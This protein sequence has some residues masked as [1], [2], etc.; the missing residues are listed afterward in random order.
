MKNVMTSIANK[1]GKTA[2]FSIATLSMS[3]CSYLEPYQPDTVQG[4]ILTEQNLS[5]LQKGLS[6]DQIQQL[7][8]PPSSGKNAFNPN[9]WEYIY[10]SW[11]GEKKTRNGEH[12][13]I[14]FD[15]EGYVDSWSKKAGKA[16]LESQKGF[17]GLGIF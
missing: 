4:N 14:R 13:I 7:F 16:E 12:L 1:F 2:L 11:D 6:K 9:H 10:Y 5:I 17:F 15:N 8:G 3:A